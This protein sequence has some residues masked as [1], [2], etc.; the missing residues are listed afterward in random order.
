MEIIVTHLRTTTLNL[1]DRKEQIDKCRVIDIICIEQ[2]KLNNLQE[3]HHQQAQALLHLQLPPHVPCLIQQG[4]S[5]PMTSS[6][7]LVRDEKVF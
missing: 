4:I 1:A 5:S 7:A 6:P 3:W 2:N